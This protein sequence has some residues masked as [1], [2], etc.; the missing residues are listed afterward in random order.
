M[1][2]QGADDV[3]APMRAEHGHPERAVTVPVLSVGRCAGDQQEFD[4]AQRMAL[5]GEVQRCPS[6][7]VGG[8]RIKSLLQE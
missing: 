5:S 2:E 7:R 1:I 4:R 6:V 8:T 3:A